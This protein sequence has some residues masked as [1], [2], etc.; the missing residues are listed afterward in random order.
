[1]ADTKIATD[2]GR[3]HILDVVFDNSTQSANWY[4]GLINNS[5][6]TAVST[7]DTMASH[8]GW[9]EL[10]NYDEGTRPEWN[11][12]AASSQSMTNSTGRTFTFSATVSCK[13]YFLTDKS[14]KGATSGT[15]TTLVAW[16]SARAYDDDEQLSLKHTERSTDGN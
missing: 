3:D 2:E 4:I 12:D 13:G 14:A 15:L 11:P 6:F 8:P 10:T 5:G 7:T 16:E 1:M 9:T